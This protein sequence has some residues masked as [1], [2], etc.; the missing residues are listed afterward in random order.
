MMHQFFYHTY[1]YN[2]NKKPTVPCG[3]ANIL[4]FILSAK[5]NHHTHI[6]PSFLPYLF[7]RYTLVIL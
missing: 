7:Y 3:F 1:Y 2:I 6:F 5:N 4:L